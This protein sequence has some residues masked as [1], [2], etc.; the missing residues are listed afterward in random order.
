MSPPFKQQERTLLRVCFN[1]RSCSPLVM[2]VARLL[3]PPGTPRHDCNRVVTGSASSP[4]VVPRSWQ[5]LIPCHNRSQEYHYIKPLWGTN[6]FLLQL[7]PLHEMQY[8]SPKDSTSRIL[9]AIQNSANYNI[10]VQGQQLNC[11]ISTIEC[12]HL[13]KN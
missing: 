11:T 3:I 9:A 13:K 7:L 12:K 1:S 2:I 10:K 4:R 5:G 8:Q 6:N